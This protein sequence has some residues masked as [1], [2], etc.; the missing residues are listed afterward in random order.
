VNSSDRYMKIVWSDAGDH[1][2]ELVGV[3]KVSEVRKLS[4]F[5]LRWALKKAHA[6]RPLDTPAATSAERGASE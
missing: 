6:G 5:A 4:M 2:V 3:R 1:R